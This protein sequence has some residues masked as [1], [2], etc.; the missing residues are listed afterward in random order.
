MLQDTLLVYLQNVT[1]L[2]GDDLKLCSSIFVN[3]K[4]NCPYRGKVLCEEWLGLLT[5]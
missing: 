4:K 1:R 5:S 3:E 2:D